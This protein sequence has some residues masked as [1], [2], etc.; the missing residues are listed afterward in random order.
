MEIVVVW[1]VLLAVAC[2]VDWDARKLR[3]RGANVGLHPILWGLGTWLCFPIGL[4]YAFL[5]L[6][7]FDG[8]RVS[9]V[10][11][12]TQDVGSAGIQALASVG[13]AAAGKAAAAD[14]SIEVESFR[15]PGETNAL[16]LSVAVLGVLL[17]GLVAGSFGLI[18]V[19]VLL[20]AAYVRVRQGQLLGNAASVT[21]RNFAKLDE[22]A[23]DAARLLCLDRPRLHVLQNPYLNAF[24][25]G[26]SRPFSVVLHSATV[27]AFDEEELRFLLAHEFGHIRAGHTFWLTMIAPLGKTIPGFDL[28][29]G[30]WQR[31]AEYTCDRAGLLVSRDL[32]AAVRAL[33][34][35]SSGPSAADHVDVDAFLQQRREVEKSGLDRVGELLGTHPYV[36][37]R[38]R[39]L[40]DYAE[41]SGIAPP[42][43][44]GDELRVDPAPRTA[45][46]E[47]Q[48]MEARDRTP[49]DPGESRAQS[50]D[51]VALHGGAEASVASAPEPTAGDQLAGGGWVSVNEA[52]PVRPE[53]SSEPR[54]KGGQRAT[55]VC[56]RCG[57][58]YRLGLG[59]FW[60]NETV[61]KPCWTGEPPGDS[62]NGGPNSEGG[63]E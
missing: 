20:G 21:P 16:A 26:F 25:I 44:K 19:L 52:K 6:F 41:V 1:L 57:Q 51:P 62:A 45:S 3:E 54:A 34:K 39:H 59:T 28:L 55:K 38:I 4:L 37:N 29:F 12:V 42:A 14:G 13:T 43:S 35:L 18:G 36:T 40:V 22:L 50:S 56:A 2:I 32:P 48:A 23:E 9:S 17:V 27:D 58:E 53:E 61:C 46:V 33:I 47:E 24:A 5:R 15:Y 30:V 10:A 7:V 60:F 8:G 49:E 63:T 31:R 11:K